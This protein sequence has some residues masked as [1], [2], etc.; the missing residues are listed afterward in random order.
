MEMSDFVVVVSLPREHIKNRSEEFICN[1]I[2]Y[3]SSKKIYIFWPCI[4]FCHE[5][6]RL[7]RNFYDFTNPERLK[8]YISK[9]LYN[10]CLL[11]IWEY[12]R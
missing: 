7:C 3:E 11:V 6:N 10:Q 8:S 9:T 1:W 2:L 5:T 4:G 12:A